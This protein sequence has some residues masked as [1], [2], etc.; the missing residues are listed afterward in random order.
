MRPYGSRWQAQSYE[1]VGPF[2]THDR[3]YSQ[4]GPVTHAGKSGQVK[5]YK[6][7]APPAPSANCSLT[8]PRPASGFGTLCQFYAL[9]G[10]LQDVLEFPARIFAWDSCQPR[11]TL[12]RVP[13]QMKGPAPNF[14]KTRDEPFE[15]PDITRCRA[16]SLKTGTFCRKFGRVSPINWTFPK[17]STCIK[18]QFI[19]PT[20]S[21][22]NVIS[23]KSHKWPSAFQ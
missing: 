23:C 5:S 19:S 22:H 10:I 13:Q 15:I 2:C 11:K 18:T 12:P 9:E 7:Q 14:S 21:M 17:I 8:G 4:H 3:L 16:H 20:G 1:S 6:R